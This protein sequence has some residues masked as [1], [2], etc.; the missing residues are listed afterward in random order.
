[1][2]FSLFAGCNKSD[3]DKSSST[4]EMFGKLWALNQQVG[5]NLKKNNNTTLRP[6]D[7]QNTFLSPSPR[8]RT[9]KLL[10]NKTLKAEHENSTVGFLTFISRINDRVW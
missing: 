4:V 6:S 5:I 10:R 1:M 9:I 7:V 2:K 8:P 3:P